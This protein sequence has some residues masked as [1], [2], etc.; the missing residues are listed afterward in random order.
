VFEP[1]YIVRRLAFHGVNGEPAERRMGKAYELPMLPARGQDVQLPGE[2][3][4]RR[5]MRVTLIVRPAGTTWTPGFKLT[6]AV[7]V[8]V[9]GD[10]YDDEASWTAAVNHALAEGWRALSV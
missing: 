4:P 10:E 6:E 3:E 5:I 9:D 8:E 2:V 7:R 1:Y